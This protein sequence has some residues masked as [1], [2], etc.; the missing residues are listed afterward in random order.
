MHTT[1]W[2]S[3]CDVKE[4]RK[5]QKRNPFLT[6]PRFLAFYAFSVFFV[7]LSSLGFSLEGRRSPPYGTVARRKIIFNVVLSHVTICFPFHHAD[8]F[9]TPRSEIERQ[10]ATESKSDMMKCNKPT[11][12]TCELRDFYNIRE[13][14]KLWLPRELDRLEESENVAWFSA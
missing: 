13:K 1:N 3:K 9:R 4:T 6:Q 14:G 10:R 7:S 8:T 12:R 2:F 5:Q 11:E